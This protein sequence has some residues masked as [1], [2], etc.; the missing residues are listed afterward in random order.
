[1]IRPAYHARAE[2]TIDHPTPG[3]AVDEPY[4]VIY[5][6]VYRT[7]DR[8][9]GVAP[10]FGYSVH[11]GEGARPEWYGV[12]IAPTGGSAGRGRSFGHSLA[13]AD[14]AEAIAESMAIVAGW[15]PGMVLHMA[16]DG[17]PP[18]TRWG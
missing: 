7:G 2:G 16:E 5:V 10:S 8:A 3:R 9:A 13:A 4:E 11:V 14:R 18:Q 17:V 12:R 6:E 1:M 15:H